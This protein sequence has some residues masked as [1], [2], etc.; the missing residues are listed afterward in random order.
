MTAL[1]QQ[2][3]EVAAAWGVSVDDLP[4]KVGREVDA[5]VEAARAGAYNALVVAGVDPFD[6]R[7]PDDVIAALEAVPFL[8]SIEV[9]PSAVT[10][11]ADVVLP[12]S[13]ITQRAGTFVDWE[14]RTRVFGQVFR[15]SLALTDARVL[16]MIAD[17]LDRPVGRQDVAGMRKEAAALAPSGSGRREVPSVAASSVSASS[18]QAVVSTWHH[19]LDEGTLQR[20]DDDLAA[21]ARTAVARVSAATAS[22]A[23]LTDF[24]TLS[25]DAGSLDLPVVIT[26]MPDGVVWLPTNSHNSNVR[27]VLG[28]DHGAI[29]SLASG[30]GA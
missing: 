25:T 16:A 4:T 27:R 18:G 7:R 12:V 19:L 23:G 5:I 2:R 3:A 22:A 17:E 13:T 20:G 15:T 21:T 1:L 28:V 30:G 24:V 9:R 26:D 10:E 8:V 6:T 29:V 14:G 11:F